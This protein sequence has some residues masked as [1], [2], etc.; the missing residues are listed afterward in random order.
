MTTAIHF[1]VFA[2]IIYLFIYLFEL[3]RRNFIIIYGLQFIYLA[4]ASVF[5]DSH[6]TSPSCSQQESDF[7]MDNLTDVLQQTVDQGNA[8]AVFPPNIMLNSVELL[9]NVRRVLHDTTVS[10]NQKIQC[11]TLLPNS[12]GTKNIMQYFNVTRHMVD[13]AKRL[14]ET[15]GVLSTPDTKQGIHK[16]DTNEI[17]ELYFVWHF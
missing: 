6:V 3:R 12:W 5:S 4:M 8:D 15:K 17:V 14:R 2:E 10:S 7:I 9:N 16:V 11:L 1:I 13:T